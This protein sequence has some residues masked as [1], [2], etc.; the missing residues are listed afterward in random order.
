MSAS[1]PKQW[2]DK[3]TEDLAV[4][5]LV[6][7]EEHTAHACFLS[8]QCIEKALK[9]YLLEKAQTYPRSHKLVDLLKECEQFEPAFSQFLVDCTVVDQYYVPTRYPDGV[10]RGKP[11]G[12]PSDVEAQ[13]AILAAEQILNFVV[14]HILPPT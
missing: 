6:L 2:L 11:S 10:P 5:K 7:A 1:L 14:E 4:A 9:A 13:E 8:Q 3:A 12:M